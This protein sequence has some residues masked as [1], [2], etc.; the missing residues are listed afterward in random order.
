MEQDLST[1]MSMNN[2]TNHQAEEL[3]KQLVAAKLI[4][5]KPSL[6]GYARDMQVLL[7]HTDKEV[8][9]AYRNMLTIGE[10]STHDQGTTLLIQLEAM[11]NDEMF[12]FD[13]L[14]RT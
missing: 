10:I 1:S 14:G 13:R 12:A 8:T 6:Y 5:P 11:T 3:Y 7:H 4:L 9:T 2:F